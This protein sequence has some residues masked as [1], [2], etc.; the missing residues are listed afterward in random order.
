MTRTCNTNRTSIIG[1][2]Q[3]RHTIQN[4]IS[5][6]PGCMNHNKILYRSCWVFSSAINQST[7]IL[8]RT[9]GKHL[10][11]H[12][13]WQQSLAKITTG[14]QQWPHRANN[15][16]SLCTP[17]LKNIMSGYR[18]DAD[19]CVAKHRRAIITASRVAVRRRHLAGCQTRWSPPSN[20]SDQNKGSVTN[21][22]SCNI[23]PG[24]W[25]PFHQPQHRHIEIFL[26]L[27]PL[28]WIYMNIFIACAVVVIVG[29]VQRKLGGQFSFMLPLRTFAVRPLQEQN[30]FSH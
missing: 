20:S 5:V 6:S 10:V 7:N 12:I 11:Q 9:E 29:L 8:Y 26:L 16:S 1:Q 25:K 30:A 21:T 18:G 19:A 24:P 4:S 14:H 3:G 27:T 23:S 13:H 22:D 28:I 17:W 15:A 2:I